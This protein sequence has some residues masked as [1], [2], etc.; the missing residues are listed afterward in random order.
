[1]LIALC[2]KHSGWNCSPAG[3]LWIHGTVICAINISNL[4]VASLEAE[5]GL[6]RQGVF[7]M[8]LDIRENSGSF[9]D[10]SVRSRNLC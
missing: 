6:K 10:T 3:Q 7:L 4:A 5:H 1:M 8:T 2:S 9:L